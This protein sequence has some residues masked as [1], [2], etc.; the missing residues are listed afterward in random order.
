M[1]NE[2]LPSGSSN[3]GPSTRNSRLLSSRLRSS[4]VPPIQA[5][6]QTQQQR[7][8]NSDTPTGDGL[9]ATIGAGTKSLSGRKSSSDLRPSQHPSQY[10]ITALYAF[11]IAEIAHRAPPPQRANL[12]EGFTNQ[13]GL[14]GDRPLDQQSS[15]I[16]SRPVSC[17]KAAIG[18]AS[19]PTTSE[20]PSSTCSATS[21]EFSLTSAL[22]PAIAREGSQ[23]VS[24]QSGVGTPHHQIDSDS[25]GKV[26]IYESKR[27]TLTPTAAGSKQP[28]YNLV[29]GA[30][31]FTTDLGLSTPTDISASR[32][33]M[34]LGRKWNGRQGS[35]KVIL[36]DSLASHSNVICSSLSDE[37]FIKPRLRTIS[38]ASH[39]H[40]RKSPPP[41]VSS[42]RKTRADIPPS[43]SPCPLTPRQPLSRQMARPSTAVSSARP[44]TTNMAEGS[45]SFDYNKSMMQLQVIRPPRST[46]RAASPIRPPKYPERAPFN[47]QINEMEERPK[48][49]FDYH[50][51][52]KWEML[53]EVNPEEEE[54]STK[55]N[56]QEISRQV[57]DGANRWKTIEAWRNKARI[58]SEDSFV[59]TKRAMHDEALWDE[60]MRDARSSPSS[61]SSPPMVQS[62]MIL[63]AADSL[64]SMSSVAPSLFTAL[65]ESPMK[66]AATF[67]KTQRPSNSPRTL[68]CSP[69]A[70][71]M[72]SSSS[73]KMI[74]RHIPETRL[75]S[76]N[77]EAT[78][79]KV[80]GTF[81]QIDSNY[82][83]P[84]RVQRPSTGSEII[85]QSR[86]PFP[87]Q[88]ES[89]VFKS[90]SP[91]TQSV[92]SDR[93]SDVFESADEGEISHSS[94][95][96]AHQVERKSQ[97]YSTGQLNAQKRA[98]RLFGRCE[99]VTTLSTKKDE[100]N[101]LLF[102]KPT[103]HLSTAQ[104]MALSEEAESGALDPAEL[105][106]RHAQLLTR[107]EA[108]EAGDDVTSESLP[109]PEL[110]RLSHTSKEDDSFDAPKSPEWTL[111][112]KAKENYFVNNSLIKNKT[113]KKGS[114]N[115]SL[116]N[117]L[118]SPP[119][120]PPPPR[121]TKRRSRR[122]ST[123]KGQVEE[124][125]SLN[126]PVVAAAATAAATFVKL[127]HLPIQLFETP[128][129]SSWRNNMTVEQFEDFS[130]TFGSKEMHRQ[131]V[132]EELSVTEWNF[133]ISINSILR[134]FSL[135]LRNKDLSF[136]D[137]VP[138]EVARLFN[139]LDD[140]LSFH[141]KLL[142][143]LDKVKNRHPSV[144]IV[145]IAAAI[146]KHI[147]GLSIHQSYLVNFEKVTT[148]LEDIRK[149]EKRGDLT[150]FEQVVERQSRLPE[151]RGMGLTSFLLKPIQRL[152]KYPLFFKVRF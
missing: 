18:S 135:P 93:C 11:Q 108:G 3:A 92:R 90:I 35:K 102:R 42:N 146:G 84:L 47:D 109:T 43:P 59:T 103:F 72:M 138:L 39:K 149:S 100:D 126:K 62:N 61:S 105:Q 64:Q 94:P 58:S 21:S 118:A 125:S 71:M 148:L 77:E 79:S 22:P 75:G 143:S 122:I 26:A 144:L 116:Y 69:K 147:Q 48:T 81:P 16:E 5:Q 50:D 82:S 54:E 133:V 113:N 106:S 2:L 19:T 112:E 76:K 140:I 66:A 78:T 55:S 8:R 67:Q 28:N 70:M 121:P 104:L 41:P 14:V 134:T 46:R 91:R 25:P 129:Q 12:E 73:R 9:H 30:A 23:V 32:P 117:D 65:S 88:G 80:P 38:S 7:L 17:S 136:Q 15:T 31:Q 137:H 20:R 111:D 124:A 34:K 101:K 107:D 132:I 142:K 130:K 89:T 57:K 114:D 131:E 36:K 63:V 1:I 119:P 95:L 40:S 29:N 27:T 145:C 44:F 56:G 85:K 24:S 60:T 52:I 74:L 110:S 98:S 150:I 45:S 151:C 37:E 49:S 139:W 68:D 4:K 96:S 13:I 51:G 33:K 83:L 53:N 115:A 120:P 123:L 127:D 6:Y 86:Y 10:P 141:V 99:V 97:E 128:T 152:M 87:L